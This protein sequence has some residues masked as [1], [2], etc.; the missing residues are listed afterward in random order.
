VWLC[1]VLPAGAGT[2]PTM[3][4]GVH[5]AGWVSAAWAE[6]SVVDKI[7][8]GYRLAGDLQPPLFPLFG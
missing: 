6:S 8:G 2:K 7:A 4:G 1:R 5:E 3:A